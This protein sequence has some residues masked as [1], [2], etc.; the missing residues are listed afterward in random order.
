MHR[1][2]GKRRYRD[3]LVTRDDYDSQLLFLRPIKSGSCPH[4]HSVLVSCQPSYPFHASFAC[5]SL[6]L[7][8]LCTDASPPRDSAARSRLNLPDSDQ[9]VL[10]ARHHI[11]A[12][13][14]SRQAVDCA[15]VSLTGRLLFLALSVLSVCRL[16]KDVS[17]ETHSAEIVSYDRT[18]LVSDV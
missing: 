18:T 2:V 14:G 4:R 3:R 10:S 13:L 7:S 15:L 6:R 5:L 1:G 11:F 12:V 16:T 17:R 9:L 8:L